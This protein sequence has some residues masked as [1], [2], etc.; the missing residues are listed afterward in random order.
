MTAKR[1]IAAITLS[2]ILAASVLT[3]CGASNSSQTAGEADQ[4]ASAAKTANVADYK[5]STFTGKVTSVDGNEITLSIG[6]GPM[7]KM[8]QRPDQNTDD[9][10]RQKSSD[11]DSDDANRQTPPDTNSDDTNRQ[12]PPDM[13][14]SN[15][16]MP[17]SPDA[18]SDDSNR[19]TPPDMNNSNGD[20][21]APPDADSDDTNRQTPP[22]MNNSDG[23]TG[24]N[25]SDKKQDRKNRESKTITFTV[26][27]ESVLEDI[28]MSD[29]TGDTRLTVTVDD[30]GNISKI[31]QSSDNMGPGGKGERPDSANKGKN[32]TGNKANSGSKTDD[33]ENNTS[34]GGESQL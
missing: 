34:D 15:S 19:Q 12:A 4:T 13:N 10:G 24:N 31:T 25:S 32:D 21:P 9:N 22:D 2:T 16:D 29:I 26:D 18:D 27:D 6:G 28:T 20:L 3:G 17:A 11:A 30:N 8:G 14:N 5:G 33:K 1:K 23:D 7:G